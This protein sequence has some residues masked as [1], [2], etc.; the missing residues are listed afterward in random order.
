MYIVDVSPNTCSVFSD[1]TRVFKL[2]DAHSCDFFVQ[3]LDLLGD[4]LLEA[5]RLC[6]VQGGV[7]HPHLGGLHRLQSSGV[8]F[9]S[10]QATSLP[11]KQLVHQVVR[12]TVVE[13]P[14][15]MFK[16]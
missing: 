6:L 14:A 9:Q 3:E 10:L 11:L 12:V 1:V 16:L 8:L 13:R 4:V 7:L 5:R 15:N 2:G